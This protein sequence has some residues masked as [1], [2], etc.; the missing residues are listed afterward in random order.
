[1]L[2]GRALIVVREDATAD[3]RTW[4][5]VEHHFKPAAHYIEDVRA[6]DLEVGRWLNSLELPNWHYFHDY[7]EVWIKK[8]RR[9]LAATPPREAD[10]DC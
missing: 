2:P 3:E 4:S 5:Y 1:M 8:T 6:G 10:D 7:L 9:E